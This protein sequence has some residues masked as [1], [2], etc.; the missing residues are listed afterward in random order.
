VPEH[1]EPAPSVALDEVASATAGAPASLGDLVALGGPTTSGVV[2]AAQERVGNRAT[3]AWI[4]RLIPETLLAVGLA[5]ATRENLI[6]A[7]ATAIDNPVHYKLTMH[8]GYNKGAALKLTADDLSMMRIQTNI[9]AWEGVSAAVAD[10]ERELRERQKDRGGQPAASG[11]E[12]VRRT[13]DVSGPAVANGSIANCTAHARG[14]LYVDDTIATFIG[15]LDIIDRWDFDPKVW[16][17]ITDTSN[18]TAIGEIETIL[19]WAFLPGDPF[20]VTSVSV[21]VRQVGRGLATLTF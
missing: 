18:R 10:A 11:S 1:A 4:Q 3:T 19:G 21:P 20:D 14:E 16:G 17:T 2:L 8:Y 12:V 5:H 7:A 13:L 15:E 9:M 6:L